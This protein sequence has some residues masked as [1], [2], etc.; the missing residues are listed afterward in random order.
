VHG[1]A[2]TCHVAQ[3]LTV[4]RAFVLADHDLS[5]E[6]GY[7]ALSRGRHANYL[8]ATR[9]LDDPRAEI[10]P[11]APV[12]GDPMERLVAALKTSSAMTLAIDTEPGTLLAHARQKH[13]AAVAQRQ[14]LEHAR[15][16]PGRRRQFVSARELERDTA[17]DLTQARRASAERDHGR[18]P[19]VTDRDV[20]AESIR[21]HE[22][23]AERR[24]QLSLERDRG[25]GL[26][27]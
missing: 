1:Y 20:E 6:S 21:R 27:L 16:M 8:Y 25:R 11:A 26:G 2:I 14:K 19:F 23:L 24:L 7:T 3:G 18:H 12:R 10:A 17:H 15:W 13:A 22:Q 5:R 4:D 9:E